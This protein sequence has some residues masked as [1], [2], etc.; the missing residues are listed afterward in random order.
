MKT[1]FLHNM[2]NQMVGPANSIDR[3]VDTLCN[4]PDAANRS[5]LADNIQS[6]GKTITDLLKNLINISDEERI[7]KE[8]D[9]EK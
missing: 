1:S 6:N 2:T 4:C 8:G 9:D 3:D 7:R 5:Q